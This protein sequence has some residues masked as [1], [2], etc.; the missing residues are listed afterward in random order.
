MTA[1][2]RSVELWDREYQRWLRKRERDNARR[3]WRL[4]NEPGYRE[5][6]NAYMRAYRAGHPE[7]R[8]YHRDWMRRYRQGPGYLH[9]LACTNK[10]CTC[11]RVYRVAG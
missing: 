6:H 8:E 11:E 4:A 10:P 2:D 3:V 1:V 7:L 5:R 9:E